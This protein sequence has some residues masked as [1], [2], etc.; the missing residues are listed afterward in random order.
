MGI[1]IAGISAI[2]III[3]GTMFAITKILNIQKLFGM[4]VL[5]WLLFT[6]IFVVSAVYVFDINMSEAYS[7][8]DIKEE[9]EEFSND[10]PFVVVN[11]ENESFHY[12]TFLEAV[13]RAKDEGAATKVYFRNPKTLIWERV[14]TV[15]TQVLQVPLILQLP[16]LPRGAEVTSLAMMLNFAGEKVSKIELANEI[17]KDP[18]PLSIEDG[19]IYYGHPNDGFVGD[20]FSFEQPGYG[21]YHKPIVELAEAYLPDQI[22]DMTGASFGDILFPLHIGYP[23]WAIIHTQF[24]ELSENEFQTWDTPS[25]EIQITHYKH[26]VLITGY[27]EKHIYY[28]DPLSKEVNRPISRNRFRDSW[29][30]MGRQAV[31]FVKID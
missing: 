4:A 26:A 7:D 22:V 18:T 8:G 1:M 31:S 2:C 12:P 17:K 20:M 13:A 14:D 16:E 11:E 29:I 28:N 27:D 3:I 25:G 24:K 15:P 6:A 30:Q 19:K 9:K 23:V 21:V 10:S 5:S